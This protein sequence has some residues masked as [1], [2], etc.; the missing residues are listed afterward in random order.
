RQPIAVA[1]PMLGQSCLLAARDSLASHV[2]CLQMC[3]CD[4]QH[5][6]FPHSCGKAFPRVRRVFAGMRSGVHP[7]RAFA[8]VSGEMHLESDEALCRRFQL[9]PDPNVSKTAKS[10][11]GCMRPALI[12][13]YDRDSI[14]F[15]AVGPHPCCV[16]EWELEIVR[17]LGSREP[18]G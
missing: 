10:V 15:P 14:S 9:L 12:F 18:F 7:D 4:R 3:G 17:E 1:G 11:V 8:V 16:V 13:E 5:V 2:I 6:F